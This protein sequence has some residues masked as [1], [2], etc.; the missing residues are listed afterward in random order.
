VHVA[1]RVG[2]VGGA[3]EIVVSAESLAG[4][5]PG[6]PISEPRTVA[7]KGVVEPLAVHTVDWA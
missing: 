3:D 6:F 2:E 5:D 1:A 4:V 7:L